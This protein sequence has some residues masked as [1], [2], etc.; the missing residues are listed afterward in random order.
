VIG[1]ADA[2]SVLPGDF[3]LPSDDSIPRSFS[4][5]FESLDL[6]PSTGSDYNSLFD[7][8]KSHASVNTSAGTTTCCAKMTFTIEIDFGGQKEIILTLKYDVLFVTA[9]PCLPSPYTDIL[10]TPTSPM[11]Q[12]SERSSIR[13]AL[14][15]G[16]SLQS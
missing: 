6:S 2:N 8:T 16:S 13:S 10:S 14:S 9:H 1:A 12:D 4:I 15:S 5:T 3:A 7:I 11:F